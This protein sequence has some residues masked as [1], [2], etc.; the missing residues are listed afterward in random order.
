METFGPERLMFGS[1]WPVCLLAGSYR[2]VKSLLF[3][4][5]SVLSRE[6]QDRIFG[7]NAI[8][9][10]KLKKRHS[11]CGIDIPGPHGPGTAR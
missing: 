6:K 8:E 2:D 11:V 9:F 1:D 7:L 3:S 10:Y 5:T 4:Y